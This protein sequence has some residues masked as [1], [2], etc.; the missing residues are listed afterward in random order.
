MLFC[1]SI[2]PVA[3]LFMTLPLPPLEEV[4]QYTKSP[5]HCSLQLEQGKLALNT[6]IQ[7]QEENKQCEKQF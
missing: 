6:A 2:K 4:F 1:C 5:Q 7:T 3:F